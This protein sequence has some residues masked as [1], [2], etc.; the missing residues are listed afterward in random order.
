MGQ[1]FCR[2]FAGYFNPRSPHGERQPP[3]ASRARQRPAISIHAPRTG[4]DTSRKAENGHEKISIHAPRTGSDGILSSPTDERRFQSTLPARG[5]TT[6][7][8]A[9]HKRRRISIHAPRT[10]SDASPAMRLGKRCISIHAP[11]TGSDARGRIWHSA[12]LTFQ[13]T[14]PARG[15]TRDAAESGNHPGDFN[16]RSPHGERRMR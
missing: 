13:S 10:G 4:S 9:T 1:T 16:P 14:L 8:T 5:A 7:R 3:A 6:R 2:D 11:R 12:P 15:A